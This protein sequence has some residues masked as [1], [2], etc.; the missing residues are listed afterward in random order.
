MIKA[1]QF[2]FYDSFKKNDFSYV[3]ALR[4]LAFSGVFLFI[5]GG[6]RS[7]WMRNWTLWKYFRDYFPIRVSITSSH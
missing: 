6:R 4:N 3:F 7:T 5:L 1:V 2:N